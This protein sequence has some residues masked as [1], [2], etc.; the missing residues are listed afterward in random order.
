MGISH[1]KY[2]LEDAKRIAKHIGL[3]FEVVDKDNKKYIV[4]GKEFTSLRLTLEYV[5]SE[6]AKND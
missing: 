3:S 6:E 4:N 5:Y 1:T 2:L